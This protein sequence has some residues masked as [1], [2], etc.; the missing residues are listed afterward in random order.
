MDIYKILILIGGTFGFLG[1]CVAY[2][3]TWNESKK[4]GFS[5]R[6]LFKEAFKVA[7][8]T[9]IFFILLSIALAVIF[10]KLGL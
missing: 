9:F 5:G 6:R 4:R 1:A 10:S 2:L 8:F 7:A 3:V